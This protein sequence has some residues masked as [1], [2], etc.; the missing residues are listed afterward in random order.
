M[1]N[2]R[3]LCEYREKVEI[4]EKLINQAL[5]RSG[6]AELVRMLLQSGYSKQFV[7]NEIKKLR[8]AAEKEN[9]K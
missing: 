4:L 8:E 2:V 9:K 7:K 6:E 5:R 3:S 1:K